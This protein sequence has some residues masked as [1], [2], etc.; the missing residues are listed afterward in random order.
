[1]EKDIRHESESLDNDD[2]KQTDTE[3]KT[4]LATQRIQNN[5]T[6][7]AQ[8]QLAKAKGWGGMDRQMPN[9]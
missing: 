3:R 5:T 1:M 4:I 7:Q 6:K 9:L 8:K 2:T